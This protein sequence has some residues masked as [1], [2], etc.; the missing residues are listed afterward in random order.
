MED[1]S[2]NIPG[3]N[4]RLEEPQDAIGFHERGNRYSRNGAYER[5]IEDYNRAIEMDG[6]FAEAYYDRGFSFYEMAR[7]EEAIADLTRAIE[8]NPEAAH[9]YG[10]RSLV[11]LFTD[12]LDLAQ[13]DEEMSDTLRNRDLE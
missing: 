13:A 3:N 10:Q 5:A 6:A 8:L 7:Y 11:Y 4:R 12:R 9:Y 2:S 1:T